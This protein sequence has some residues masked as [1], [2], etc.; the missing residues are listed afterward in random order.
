[1]SSTE[2]EFVF[3][4]YLQRK[5]RGE[6]VDFEAVCAAHPRLAEELR[7]HK[8]RWD[9]YGDLL[10]EP[11]AAGAIEA[12][13]LVAG[14]YE[15]VRRL[16]GGGF[17]QVWL[18]KQQPSLQL[19]ALK[20]AHSDEFDL[21]R[22]AE[23]RRR[24]STEAVAMGRS[25]HPGIV[26]L[27][28]SGVDGEMAWMAME[29]VDGS[30]L[31][32]GLAETRALHERGELPDDYD[33]GVATLLA[34]VCDAMQ[35]AHNR[36]VIHRDLKPDNIMV[37]DAEP[38]VTDFGLARLEDL[39]LS[40][41]GSLAG[42][43]YY[44]S[45]EQVRMVVANDL[46]TRTDIFSLG[47]VLYEMLAL[48]KPFHGETVV[49]ITEQILEREPP[50]PRF[51]RPKASPELC[52]IASKA[53]EK[54]RERRYQ[55]MAD[56]AADLRRYLADE[57]ILAR[58]PTR[59]QLL[60]KWIR[61]HPVAASVI[62][63][64]SVAGVAISLLAVDLYYTGVRE[65]EN[66]VEARLQRTAADNRAKALALEHAEDRLLLL[67]QRTKELG[68]PVPQR[69][70]DFD[71]W[72]ADAKALVEG[73]P[74][75]GSGMDEFEAELLRLRAAATETKAAEA[76]PGDALDGARYFLDLCER[77]TEWLR[78]LCGRTPMPDPATEL[79]AL[80]QRDG[81]GGGEWDDVVVLQDRCS[82]YLSFPQDLSESLALCAKGDEVAL[83]ALQGRVEELMAA[84]PFDAAVACAAAKSKWWLLAA[85]GKLEEA[86]SESAADL[87]ELRRQPEV[88]PA[89]VAALE[90]TRTDL[91]RQ[92]EECAR[93][94]QDPDRAI[95]RSLRDVSL[96]QRRVCA[97]G[98]TAVFAD[99][100]QQ[101]RHDRLATL[102]AGMSEFCTS[103]TG[104]EYGEGADGEGNLSVRGRLDM[105]L[106]IDDMLLRERAVKAWEVAIA[107]TMADDA[108]RGSR[109][110]GGAFSRQAG[111]LPLGRDP[112][113]GLQEFGCAGSGEIP[114]R[115]SAG[116]LQLDGR[117]AVVLVLVPGGRA[118][119][120]YD[121]RTGR[122]L[123]L[124]TVPNT[125]GT[126]LARSFELEPFFLAKH[127][128][129]RGQWKC[130]SDSLTL[131]NDH[132][133]WSGDPSLPATGIP[134]D[135]A[136]R[137]MVNAALSLPTGAQWDHAA[138]AGGSAT[139]LVPDGELAPAPAN[140][141]DA[142]YA[143]Q[144]D[145]SREKL[146]PWNDNYAAAAPV[147]SFAPNAWGLLDMA[148]NV[149]EW[150]LDGLPK[151]PD[152]DE[153]TG[154]DSAT[155]LRTVAP[156]E[157]SR[158]LSKGG[159]YATSKLQT[160]RGEGNH[161][162]AGTHEPTQGLRPARRLER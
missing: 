67:K 29:Y 88:G 83:L 48:A 150:C 103:F 101:K 125:E 37:A 98:T 56:F 122:V 42:T 151:T 82:A 160:R 52:V 57:P 144:T 34:K 96:L 93:I 89:R 145:Q 51:L 148:G 117:S 121:R 119:C 1:M 97:L 80:R 79:A 109:W 142:A 72:L 77:E 49:Q 19:V 45:P 36:L 138:F 15:L 14:K 43:Y 155:G 115:D 92:L 41:T 105:A 64:A 161:L 162:Y 27:L 81:L 129:T 61:R 85:N 136:C 86:R 133:T 28:D 116:K 157:V 126:S 25:R 5:K 10:Q 21:E 6:E 73:S 99:P 7:A 78:R 44:M 46:D 63:V 11:S 108:Y 137:V 135:D 91:L 39:S 9:M 106:A 110:P 35:A 26:A 149:W 40:R 87:Q 59:V 147:G 2:S 16:G 69:I 20:L 154:F 8:R 74:S 128:L 153:T 66:L 102:V 120:T 47:V 50:D 140:L 146:E 134:W 152:M 54:D 75:S 131:S 65:R 112:F 70:R 68:A 104:G 12:G 94:R 24:L 95:R 90:R 31:K 23:L 84:A 38:K 22:A 111:L 143:D 118:D 53:M 114:V 60:R 62:G 18:A 4:D 124:G 58:P 30:D 127:E 32:H 13:R 107:Q 141:A 3:E 33:N 132:S 159:S 76:A 55:T 100:E 113:S 130:L 17:G 156:E 139:N 71:R 123:P 158:R